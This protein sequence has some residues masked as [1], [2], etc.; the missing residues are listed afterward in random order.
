MTT[1]KTPLRDV[2]AAEPLPGFQVRV[3]FD[4]G[5]EGVVDL[6][7]LVGKGVFARWREHPSEFFQVSVDAE[8]G[9]LV[10]PG[11]LDVAPDRLYHDAL[12]AAPRRP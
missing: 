10:W 7:D 2:V 4:D 3:T 6:S 5:V 12:E 8:A 11:G 9:T 1:N